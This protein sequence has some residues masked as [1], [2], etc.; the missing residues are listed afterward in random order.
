MGFDCCVPC[1]GTYV[2]CI[3]EAHVWGI[4]YLSSPWVHVGG[5]SAKQ[6]IYGVDISLVKHVGVHV[7]RGFL[8]GKM[9]LWSRRW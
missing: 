8:C 7:D 6:Y 9:R 5:D 2:S 4:T 3:C 1:L